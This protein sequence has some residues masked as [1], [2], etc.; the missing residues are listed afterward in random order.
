MNRAEYRRKQRQEEKKQARFWMTQ[1][2]IDRMARVRAQEMF[3]HG[4]LEFWNSER[5][6]LVHNKLTMNTDF[7][8][9]LLSAELSDITSIDMSDFG[10][11]SF[12]DDEDDEPITIVEDEVPQEVETRCVLG[13][14]WQLGD[15]RLLGGDPRNRLVG[16]IL[17]V[18]PAEIAEQIQ[19]DNL[20]EW[21][22]T[23]QVN[24]QMELMRL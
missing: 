19:S 13:D 5:A 23:I 15:H 17:D 16:L 11:D 21:C 12:D 20:R 6:M 22:K 3:K 10:F 7:D 9:D 24:M 2:E 4:V 1:A 14:L 18:N 8:F